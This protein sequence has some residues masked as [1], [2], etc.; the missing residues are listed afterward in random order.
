MPNTLLMNSV[1]TLSIRYWYMDIKFRRQ[2]QV[3]SIIG[4]MI[5]AAESADR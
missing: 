2:N 4:T 3:V 5:S 1:V